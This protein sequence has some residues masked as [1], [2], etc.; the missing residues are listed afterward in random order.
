MG[1]KSV[2]PRDPTRNDSRPSD[3]KSRRPHTPMPVENSEAAAEDHT[4]RRE[5]LPLPREEGDAKSVD[6]QHYRQK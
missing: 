5:G 1:K 4:A 2:P 6:G 3:S